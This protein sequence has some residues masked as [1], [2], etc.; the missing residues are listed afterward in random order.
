M[1]GELIGIVNAKST[2]ANIDLIGFAIPIDTAYDIAVELIEYGYITDRVEAGLKLVEINDTLTAFYYG[3]STFG[4]YVEESKYTDEIKRGDRIVS[5]NSI[6][7]STI[8]EI[9]NILSGC[10]VGETI[11][12]RVSRQ[13]R[14]LDVKLTLRE[15]VPPEVQKDKS[16]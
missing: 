14:Q 3:V 7:V 8:A 1:K 10:S 16:Q 11:T 5:V 12:I 6:E 9:K 2:G 4:V 13:G 15:Y